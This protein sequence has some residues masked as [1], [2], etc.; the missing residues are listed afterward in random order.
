MLWIDFSI[1]L[2]TSRS[3][4]SGAAPGYGMVTTSTGCCTSGISFTRSLVSAI[5]PKAISARI[6]TTV[7]TGRRMEK[8]DRNMADSL[9]RL[10]GAGHRR[11]GLGG[12]RVLHHLAVLERCHG[13][14]QQA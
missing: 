6:I 4:V 1:R 2:M 9:L 3:A 8:S 7:A 11:C 5:T 10:G 13:M 14:A 12:R